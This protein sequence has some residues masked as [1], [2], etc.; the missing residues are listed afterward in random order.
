MQAEG[1]RRPRIA[2]VGSGISGLGAS[3]LSSRQADVSI[4][5]A[6]GRPG[7]HSCTVDV[8]I[9]GDNIAVDMG[10]IVFNERAYPNLVALFDH[11]GV[12]TEDSNMSLA[13]SLDSGRFEYGGG[14]LRQLFAQKRN[15]VSPRFWSMV[16]DIVRFYRSAPTH[17]AQL[18]RDDMTLG[19][20]LSHY[21]YG[22]AFRDDHLLPMAAAIWSVARDEMLDFSA[23][24]FI[25]FHEN[26]GLLKLTNRPIWRTVSGGSRSYVERVLA[27][28]TAKVHLGTRVVRVIREPDGVVVVTQQGTRERYDHVV[29]A[30]HA[31]RALELIEQPTRAEARV[32]GNFRYNQ[33]DV[34]LHSDPALMPHRQSVWSSWNYVGESRGPGA[35]RLTVTYWMNLLQNLKSERPLF[36]TLNPDREPRPE[37]VYKTMMFEHPVMNRDAMAAQRELWSLQ[38]EG[39]LWFAGAHFG[40]GFHEDGLQAG[41]AV[42]EQMTGA[43][44]P[45]TVDEPSGRIFAETGSARGAIEEMAA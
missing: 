16:R 38:G 35:E 11:L 25:R 44:R 43:R 14:S 5:E 1:S 33:N 31:D 9:G 4:Y 37:T 36:V 17:V 32:L 6:D 13:I 7:G 21:R 42:A 24:S 12:A 39:G 2:V 3:W 8:E 10:F 19:E 26:H 22:E 30:T 27:D 29:L 18:M 15:A 41:L 34:V 40:A 20:Y 23:V 28:C 45:W